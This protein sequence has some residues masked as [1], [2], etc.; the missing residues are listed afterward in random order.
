MIALLLW[1]IFFPSALCH[2]WIDPTYKA[3]VCTPL[4]NGYS[5]MRSFWRSYQPRRDAD[6][7]RGTKFKTDSSYMWLP[8]TEPAPYWHKDDNAVGLACGNDSS[9]G[10][11]HFLHGYNCFNNRKDDA[12]RTKIAFDAAAVRE[13]CC[14][15]QDLVESA[16]TPESS[17]SLGFVTRHP[18]ERLLSGYRHWCETH[19]NPNQCFT[20]PVLDDFDLFVTR[21]YEQK[22]SLFTN[23]HWM[24]QTSYEC[25]RRMLVAPRSRKL[26]LSASDFAQRTREVLKSFPRALLDEHF[27]LDRRPVNTKDELCRYYTTPR[28]AHLVQLM[29]SMDLTALGYS[30]DVVEWMSCPTWQ[31]ISR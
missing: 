28:L 4:K 18:A 3:M 19:K 10:V 8:E 27:S 6:R 13:G 24:P 9:C 21:L 12:F 23:G 5:N 26:D 29:Y 22:S 30:A 7:L 15:Q 25:V 20:S 16:Y 1:V 31:G 2:L 11:C 17:Y 14:K